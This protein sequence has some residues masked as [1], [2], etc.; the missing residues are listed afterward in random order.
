MTTVAASAGTS[1]IA[2]R[3]A[4]N[5][6][7]SP[8]NRSGYESAGMS[9]LFPGAPRGVN[10]RIAA[11]NR[12]A[13]FGYPT[14]GDGGDHWRD[15]EG[16][17]VRCSGCCRKRGP[18]RSACLERDSLRVMRCLPDSP[19]VTAHASSSE[20]ASLPDRGQSRRPT[21]QTCTQARRRTGVSSAANGRSA[22]RLSSRIRAQWSAGPWRLRRSTST[23]GRPI[24]CPHGSHPAATALAARLPGQENVAPGAATAVALRPSARRCSSV[25]SS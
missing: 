7:S 15:R 4:L 24:G 17:G 13:T 23:R 14:D 2:V 3:M 20:S 12:L 8:S 22:A 25:S 10:R 11:I 1:L 21:A 5:I 16:R 18:P 6:G 9:H 19:V